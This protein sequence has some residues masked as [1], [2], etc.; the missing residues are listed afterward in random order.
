M[1]LGVQWA[2]DWALG[3][4][5]MAQAKRVELIELDRAI[6]DGDHGE[7]LARGFAAVANQITNTNFNTVDEVLKAIATTLLSTVGGASGPLLG[8]AFL[9][10]SKVVSGEEIDAND[11]VAII[12]AALDG[13]QARG[14]A[15]EGE[16]TMVDAWAP[17][18]RAAKAAVQNGADASEVW[19][20]AA[21]GAMA[22]S[23]STLALVASKGRASYLGQRSAG[24]KDPG[25]CSSAYII[26]EAAK[27]AGCE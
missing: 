25:A 9:R 21:S 10:G 14:K 7:N 11:V 5:D 23:E 18:L 12:E 1:T 2:R 16:K 20:A 19:Q 24:H 22:G 3:C 13:I 17:A 27:A 26:L 6:G 15:G 8:T 4:N